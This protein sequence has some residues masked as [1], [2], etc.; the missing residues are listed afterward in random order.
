MN[1]NYFSIRDVKFQHCRIF[2]SVNLMV[3]KNSTFR[4]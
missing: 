1:L 4:F 2:G 3:G